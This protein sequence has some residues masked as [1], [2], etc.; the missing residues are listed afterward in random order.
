V[1]DDN[2]AWKALCVYAAHPERFSREHPSLE[3]WEIKT[4]KPPK[5]RRR[6]VTLQRAMKAASKAGIAVAGATLTPEGVKLDI[7][8]AVQHSPNPWDSVQ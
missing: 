3:P 6:P 4:I 5:K 7:G 2:A 1:S 8:E